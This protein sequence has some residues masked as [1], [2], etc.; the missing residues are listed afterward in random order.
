MNAS[1]IPRSRTFAV[2]AI[3]ILILLLMLPN[4]IWLASAS[5]IVVW[6]EA[7]IVPTMLLLVWYALFGAWPWVACLLLTPFAA[8]APLEAFYI[9]QYHHPTSAEIIA[10][11]IAT[12]PRESREYLG[13]LLIPLLSCMAAGLL[14]ALLAAW[15]SYRAH[16]R[17]THR[18][19][20]WILVVALFTP[21]IVVIVAAASVNGGIGVRTNSG[22]RTLISLAAPIKQGYPFGIFQRVAEYRDEWIAMRT[23]AAKL[24]T[25][26]FHA[27]RIGHLGARQVYVL[28]LG[29]SSRRDHWQLF[30]YDRAT[31]PELSNLHNLVPIPRML[32]SWPESIAAIPLVL[33]RKPIASMSVAWKEA[34]ILRAM[35]EAGYTTYWISN[36][37][38][39]GAF[40]SPVS[41]YA[42]E[43]QHVEWLNHASW[44]AP[45]SYDGNL[46]QPLRD[47]L[48]D[49]NK[50]LFIVLHMMGSH[51]NY[52]YRYPAAFRHFLPMYSNRNTNVAAG[53][54]IRN[55][56]DNTILYT[57]HVL[58]QIIGVLRNSGAVTALWFVS[59][60]GETLPTPTCSKMGHGIGSRYDFQVPALFWYSDSYAQ[61]F[62][63]RVM[64]L[65]SN[66]GQ[67]TLSAST[68]ESLID[69]AGISFPSH[70]ETWSLFS[71]QWQYHARI[72]N[73]MWQTDYDKADFGKG[74]EIVLPP[75]VHTS[76]VDDLQ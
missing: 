40:D 24:A 12:N 62:P 53:E 17:W 69:M 49:S 55:S 20:A 57:D 10:T 15:L 19:R 3:A 41:M 50:D 8:L 23:D 29:E 48:H 2:G 33:T 22:E 9:F 74:C 13:P 16:L 76:A 26:R 36:Q 59:D 65:R 39:I 63:Q 11:I 4:L 70:D 27:A 71:P 52:D 64:S 73:P 44:T 46:I 37:L 45:G 51:I 25:F 58:A 34:S 67:R 1:D 75:N 43:A 54:R 66:A 68:F 60:H 61:A 21:L 31:N 72:V 14:I 35:Q 30:G 6:V 47:A 7:L 5:G 28:V 56:Y 38:A 18:A 42:Y 32:G